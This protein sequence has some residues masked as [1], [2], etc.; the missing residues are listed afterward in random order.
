MTA[1]NQIA[2]PELDSYEKLIERARDKIASRQKVR[3]A[4]VFGTDGN[5]AQ[6][7]SRAVKENLVEPIFV[8]DKKSFDSF[9]TKFSFDGNNLQFVDAATS[10]EAVSSL[11]RL[12]AEGK[13]DLIAKGRHVSLRSFVELLSKHG[14]GLVPAGKMLSHIAVI[15]AKRYP[16]LLTLL[17]VGVVPQPD[18]KQKITLI[19]QATQFTRQI[20]QLDV[21]RVAVLAAVEVVYPQMPVTLE[22]AV[23]SKM[24]ERGQIKPAL[25]DG[26]LSF[27]C[28]VD[29]FAAHSKGLHSSEVAGQ[30]DVMLAPNAETATGI[31]RALGLYG[32]SQLGGLLW[33]ATIPIAVG[34][35]ADSVDTMYHSLILGILAA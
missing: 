29:M 8:G 27:D 1:E 4:L 15:K 23:L 12:A 26:P 11:A 14:D 16:K 3:A 25:V 31:Y 7:F 10:E 2:I 33:G 28:S 24:A 34:T 20:L 32:N 22:A 35:Q 30:A 13:V 9:C 18:L 19:Q 6:A 5:M 17:D 21:P